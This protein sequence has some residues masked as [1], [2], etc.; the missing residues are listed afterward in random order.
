MFI[1]VLFNYSKFR[2]TFLVFMYNILL[3][4][5]IWLKLAP[6]RINHSLYLYFYTKCTIHIE[7]SAF[8]RLLLSLHKPSMLQVHYLHGEF[9]TLYT[10]FL[11]HQAFLNTLLHSELGWI[12]LFLWFMKSGNGLIKLTS[13]TIFVHVTFKVR[14]KP[15]CFCYN[16]KNNV[17]EKL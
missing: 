14:L 11:L 6:T 3:Q 4:K 8:F 9:S 5:K 7:D 1:A 13:V 12:I 17:G 16:W 15:M 2:I 10:L